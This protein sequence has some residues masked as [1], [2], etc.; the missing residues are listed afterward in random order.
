MAKI[1]KYHFENIGESLHIE[2]PCKVGLDRDPV[3][4]AVKS[5]PQHPSILKIK[6][7]TNSSA[8]FSFHVSQY[9]CGFRKVF[10]VLTT[11]LSMTEK[12][13]ESLDSGGNFGAL[14]TKLSK[15][16]DCLS[17][18]LLVAKLHASGLDMP[19][20]KLLHS[21]LTKRRQRVKINKTYS[22]C[23]EIIFGVP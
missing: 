4:S 9:K 13:E 8:S 23:S 20:L 16:F 15:A 22:S 3:V 17:H 11:L 21:F 5:F 6:E 10:S 14:L 12:W 7:N 2:P 19:S 1:F 18:D